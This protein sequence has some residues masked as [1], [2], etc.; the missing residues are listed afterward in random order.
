MK[1]GP[2]ELERGR[3]VGVVFGES[4][5]GFEVATVIERVGIDDDEGNVPVEDGI[6]VEL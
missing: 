4:H 3:V 2:V 6:L 1:E 5:F